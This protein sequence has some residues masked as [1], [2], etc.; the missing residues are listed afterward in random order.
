MSHPAN[1]LRIK[2]QPGETL[3]IRYC[4]INGFRIRRRLSRVGHRHR[5]ATPAR[6][7]N[8][9]ADCGPATPISPCEFDELAALRKAQCWG[10]PLFQPSHPNY[11]RTMA[12]LTE[13]EA[14]ERAVSA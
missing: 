7:L 14:K 3:V 13:L 5:S 8:R 6:N 1:N 2:M 9:G 10:T 4:A 12:R 11:R